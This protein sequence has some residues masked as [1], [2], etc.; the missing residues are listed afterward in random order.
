MMLEPSIQPIHA[1][2]NVVLGKEEFPDPSAHSQLPLLIV[3]YPQPAD[4]SLTYPGTAGLQSSMRG[5]SHKFNIALRMLH[6]ARQ[7]SRLFVPLSHHRLSDPLDLSRSVLDHART[8]RTGSSSIHKQATITSNTNVALPLSYF[9]TTEEH[10]PCLWPDVLKVNTRTGIRA[11]VSG[12]WQVKR[13]R[14]GGG[15]TE[16]WTY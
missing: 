7:K 10:V 5:A 2:E 3:V 4:R 1:G 8:G 9:R 14:A 15:L 13:L 11:T 12:P 16:C 6:Y